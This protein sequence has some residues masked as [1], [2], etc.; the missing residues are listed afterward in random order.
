MWHHILKY[1]ADKSCTCQTLQ[2]L[3]E[4]QLFLIVDISTTFA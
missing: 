1:E 4:E 3:Y 2:V